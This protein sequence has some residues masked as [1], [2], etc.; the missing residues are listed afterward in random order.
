MTYK[1]DAADP[2]TDPKA[3]AFLKS[4]TDLRQM[5]FARP[6]TK[7]QMEKLQQNYGK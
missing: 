5:L 6:L 7:E 4:G 1:G 2:K 3:W